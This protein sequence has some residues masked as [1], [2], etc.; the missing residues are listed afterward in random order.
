MS[1]KKTI[2]NRRKE[3]D[4][5]EMS[6]QSDAVFAKRLKSELHAP[7]KGKVLYLKYLS[8]AA[9]LGI[10]ISLG[11]WAVNSSKIQQDKKQLVANLTNTSAGAR[12]EGIYHFDDEYK[13]EDRQIIEVLINILHKD[14]N[15]NVKIATIDAL[16]KFPQNELIRTNLIKALGNEKTP[17]VQIKL[18]K[19]LSILRENRAQKPLK[20][21]IESKETLPIVVNNA[22]LAMAE[23][24]QNQ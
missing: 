22:T 23:I 6:T 21:L 1:L 19:S 20:K 12:L 8:V 9:S 13:K 3:F 24:S 18:I 16:L 2:Q 10:L 5:Q 14:S 4:N 15:V 11:V 7:T 17:L